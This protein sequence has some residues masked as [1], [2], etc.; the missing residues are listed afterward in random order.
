[1]T[2]LAWQTAI[3]GLVTARAA[4]VASEPCEAFVGE[5]RAWF[6]SVSNSPG[7]KLTCDVQRWWREF[8]VQQAA[9]LT[10]G[11][12]TPEV[13]ASLLNEYVRRYSRPSSF[14][15]REALPFLN[16]AAELGSDLPHVA[17]L[18]AFERAMLR[19]GSALA[20]DPD[21]ARVRVFQSEC[22]VQADPLAEVVCFHAPAGHV[23][24]AA[25]RALPVPAVEDNVYR[26]VIAPGLPNLA[27]ECSEE[28]AMLF[29]AIRATGTCSRR[30]SESAFRRLWEAGALRNTV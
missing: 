17:A 27:A 8:R 30:T 26:I 24:A 4:G 18:A 9:P 5:E 11:A 10:L 16:L 1:M 20:D 21:L 13:R 15:L 2:L 14:F 12:L 7:F 25:A 3:A 23:L 6:E 28:E 29:E 19:L 22:S